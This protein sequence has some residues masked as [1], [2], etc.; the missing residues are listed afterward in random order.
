M[1][2]MRLSV[3]VAA[4]ALPAVALAVLGTSHP[5]ALTPA[6]APWWGGLHV[7]HLPGHTAGH[8]GF[9]SEKHQLLFCGDLVAIWRW[10]TQF[11]PFYLNTDSR[12]LRAS[13][14]RALELRPRLVVPNHYSRWAGFDPA[15]FAERF[16]RFA[17]R[18]LGRKLEPLIHTDHLW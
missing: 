16:E 8:C 12:K 1:V 17:R 2:S 3:A 5:V 14:Q 4:T 6:S 15:Y 13:L 18:K 7:V 9:W 11:P 10:W